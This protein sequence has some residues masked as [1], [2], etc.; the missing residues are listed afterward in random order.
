M[1]VGGL[2]IMGN[3]TALKAASAP[4]IWVVYPIDTVPHQWWVI[5]VWFLLAIA[6]VVVQLS[7]TTK[8]G[9]KKR[10]R[11]EADKQ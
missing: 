4:G 6:G 10:R 9:S 1:L 8:T 7:T 2:A 5:G 3:P 11:R